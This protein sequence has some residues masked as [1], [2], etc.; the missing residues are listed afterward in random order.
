MK[1]KLSVKKVD[2]NRM[3]A[4]FFLFLK[5]ENSRNEADHV[6]KEWTKYSIK[7]TRK[8][9]N[10]LRL[11][12]GTLYGIKHALEIKVCKYIKKKTFELEYQK[13][14]LFQEKEIWFLI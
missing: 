4:F 14:C 10:A 5:D 9:M 8:E 6:W 3:E 7:R 2:S 1:M 12:Y 13:N 11:Y